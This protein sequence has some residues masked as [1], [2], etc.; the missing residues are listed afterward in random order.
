MSRFNNNW[1]R[2]TI[3]LTDTLVSLL[4]VV[5]AYELRFNFKIPSSELSGLST[6]IIFLVAVRIVTFFIFGTYT[7]MIRYTSSEDALRIFYTVTIG[8]LFTGASNFVALYIHNKYLV[9]FSVLII[10]YFITMLFMMGF[11]VGIKMLV[12][13]IEQID[14]IRSTVFIYDVSKEGIITKHTLEKD[15]D[16]H[17]QV[18]GFFDDNPS[19][20]SQKIEGVTIYNIRHDLDKMLKDYRPDQ[21]II[22]TQITPQKR[23]EIV[24]KCLRYHVKVLQLPPVDDWING[25]L[26]SKQIREIKIEELLERE[27]IRLDVENI[28]DQIT[29]KKILITGASGS[30]GSE[31]V[32]QLTTFKPKQ[33]ILLDQAESA[34]FELDIELSSLLL[35]NN[36][37]IVI[38]DVRNEERMENVFNTFRPNIVYHA[39]AYKHVPL[40]EDNPSESILTNVLGTKICADLAV[41]YSVEKFVLVSTDKAVNPTSVMGASKRIA[42]IY[43]QSLNYNSDNNPSNHT[44]FI[45][46]RFGN[47]LGSNGS[48]IPLFRKQIA[49]GGP[50]TV[51][52]SEVTRFF[53]TIPEA[54]RLV[55]EA[56]AIGNG[57]EIFIFDMGEPIKIVDLAKKMIQLSGFEPEKD[58]KIIFT[59]LRPGEKLY[60]E[61]L[62]NQENTL[63]THH[64]KIMIAKVHEY[65]FKQIN[66][67]ICELI[68]LFPMQNNTAIV[69]KMKDIVPEFR[70]NN[71]VYQKLDKEKS[72]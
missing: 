51:T 36:Y 31:I 72:F 17:Y 28:R 69:T 54:C 7:G 71:S 39:A 50:L 33:L 16:K 46:T 20:I 63:P 42:E 58:I 53:M 14:K 6:G 5:L 18:I 26:N 2:Y 34:L 59:G 24:D 11:R 52:D 13:G 41:K 23:N 55:L 48:V 60:E 61:L 25:E 27:P 56:G 57:G 65:P 30:I 44:R 43:V 1:P 10:D 32:R 35:H 19:F 8:T 45:T 64:P 29:G 62:N 9:P 66:A 22:S 67:D 37:E 15:T 21:F 12:E 3:F 47:V 40:M 38:G 4:S 68:A 70:S 49:S